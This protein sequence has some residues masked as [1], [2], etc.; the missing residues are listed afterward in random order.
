VLGL[1]LLI[2]SSVEESAVWLQSRAR[3]DHHRATIKNVFAGR[4]APT[5]AR[6]ILGTK[7]GVC[8]RVLD[9]GGRFSLARSPGSACLSRAGAVMR[10]ERAVRHAYAWNRS[11]V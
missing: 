3:S 4:F 11:I 6:G 5:T 1:T 9:A 8:G 10:L 2:R 7:S